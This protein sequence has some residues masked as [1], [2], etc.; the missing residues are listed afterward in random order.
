VQILSPMNLGS[1][2]QSEED[3]VYGTW[4]SLDQIEQQISINL[5]GISTAAATLITSTH[6]SRRVQT[7]VAFFTMADRNSLP[8]EA[9]TLDERTHVSNSIE[10]LGG[11]FSAGLH[12]GLGPPAFIPLSHMPLSVDGKVAY[13]DLL[14]FFS[15]LPQS[16]SSEVDDTWVHVPTPSNSSDG[17][18]ALTYTDMSEE[19]QNPLTA[20]EEKMRLLSYP[21]HR[22]SLDRRTAFFSTVIPLLL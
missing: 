11:V 7:P 17:V 16:H 18:E 6:S 1:G 3:A 10:E 14:A 15:T 20:A 4:V 13:T 8:K 9:L 12:P 19:A 2:V 5:P 22:G 21:S